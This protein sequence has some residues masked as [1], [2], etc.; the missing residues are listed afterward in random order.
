M[1]NRHGH[2]R[3]TTDGGA[4]EVAFPKPIDVESVLAE[5]M[6]TEPPVFTAI[7]RHVLF[8]ATERSEEMAVDN[9]VLVTM[10]PRDPYFSAIQ[11]QASFSADRKATEVILYE[12]PYRPEELRAPGLNLDPKERWMNPVAFWVAEHPQEARAGFD[13]AVAAAK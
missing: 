2:Q 6:E 8:E 12:N 5:A 10:D 4:T 11:D 13:A 3:N 9:A 7:G 1:G